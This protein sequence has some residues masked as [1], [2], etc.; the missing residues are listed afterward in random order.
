[1]KRLGP[2]KVTIV[3]AAMMLADILSGLWLRR[4]VAVVGVRQCQ[5]TAE[6]VPPPTRMAA[7]VVRTRY[8]QR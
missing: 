2:M 1:M 8:E 7:F 5:A 6:G 4:L 3:K